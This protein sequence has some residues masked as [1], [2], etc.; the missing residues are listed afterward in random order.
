MDDAQAEQQSDALNDFLNAFDLAMRIRN[1]SHAEMLAI[2]FSKTRP[3]APEGIEKRALVQLERCEYSAAIELFNIAMN[4]FPERHENFA[5]AGK[6]LMALGKHGEAKKLAQDLITNFPRKAVG[7][8]LMA[9]V[10]KHLAKPEAQEKTLR[11]CIKA[12]PRQLK[13]YVELGN[14]LLAQ[15]KASQATIMLEAAS[16]QFSRRPVV[17]ELLSKS[18]I[19]AQDFAGAEK[20]LCHGIELNPD[21][22]RLKRSLLGIK[23]L[24]V[25]EAYFRARFETCYERL[26]E[27]EEVYEPLRERFK[28]QGVYREVHWAFSRDHALSA[29]Q[30]AQKEAP[31][32]T[33]GYLAEAMI[34]FESGAFEKASQKFREA[35]ALD[36]E[37]VEAQIGSALVQLNTNDQD[38]AVRTLTDSNVKSHCLTFLTLGA[39]EVGR[40]E[41]NRALKHFEAAYETA[42]TPGIKAFVQRQINAV[43]QSL[44]LETQY[45]SVA[46]MLC[47]E[48]SVSLFRSWSAGFCILD[49]VRIPPLSPYKLPSIARDFNEGLTSKAIS[50]CEENTRNGLVDITGLGYSDLYLDISPKEVLDVMLLNHYHY[51]SKDGAVKISPEGCS[52]VL[53]C[54]ALHGE[55]GLLFAAEGRDDCTV[56][57]FEFIPSKIERI[58]RAIKM[59][60]HLKQRLTIVSH[61]VFE[62]D[63]QTLFL[64]PYIPSRVFDEAANEDCTPVHTLSIDGYMEQS[65]Q[66]RL[67]FIKM[68][69]EGAEL[70]AL[71]GGIKTIRKCMPKLGISIY[72]ED[73]WLRVP[74]W[75]KSQNLDYKYFVG[76]HS[77][78]GR[79]MV[80]YAIRADVVPS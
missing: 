6:A 61:P 15:G 77:A 27:L 63:G 75:F 3:E 55:T 9:D 19:A 66:E 10:Y 43:T 58:R 20:A 60:P 62:T 29:A 31:E 24:Q 22:L 79:E 45:R 49:S 51:V 38:G 46:D 69:I 78:Q 64:N 16:E 17:H 4:T 44:E 76:H 47:D 33:A 14:C 53:D 54:G 57:M 13:A 34:Q 59:N 36:A 18:F 48:A 70:P 74:L 5:G 35:K 37:C 68:D 65:G 39:L 2:G 73:D 12:F 80:L 67:D 26:S 56:A 41:L 72:H 32:A 23:V 42:G 7:R 21:A 11:A 40:F 50:Y 71:K 1:Y 28:L 30:K 25:L 52:H 8:I